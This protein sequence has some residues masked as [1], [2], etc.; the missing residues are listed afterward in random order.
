MIFNITEEAKAMEHAAAAEMKDQ[1]AKSAARGRAL[2][3]IRNPNFSMGSGFSG[4]ALSTIRNPNFS[5][6]GMGGGGRGGFRGEIPRSG[7]PINALPPSGHTM[8]NVTPEKGFWSGV[9]DFMDAH[10]QGVKYGAIGLAGAGIGAAIYNDN[11]R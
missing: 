8:I 5:M 6:G 2:S 9:S 10:P 1:A 4:G 3:T 11:Y 7:Q